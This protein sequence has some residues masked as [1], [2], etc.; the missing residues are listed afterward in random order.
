MHDNQPKPDPED[1]EQLRRQLETSNIALVNIF[2]FGRRFSEIVMRVV[3]NE[4][5]HDRGPRR[6]KRKR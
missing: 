4:K 6:K 3:R 2:G 1:P 5:Q